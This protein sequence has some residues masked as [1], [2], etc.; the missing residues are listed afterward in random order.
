[1]YAPNGRLGAAHR[2]LLYATPDGVNVGAPASNP[3]AP[4]RP[5]NAWQGLP[6]ALVRRPSTPHHEL[7]PL[8]VACGFAQ[9]AFHTPHQ[10]AAGRRPP[11]PPLHY[12]GTPHL[13]PPNSRI[14]P[15]EPTPSFYDLVPHA[16]EYM[17]SSPNIVDTDRLT[18]WNTYD[19][20]SNHD[21]RHQT[22]QNPFPP[23]WD[24]SPGH[25]R[26]SQWAHAAAYRS[27]Y[28]ALPTTPY[29]PPPRHYRPL[30]TSSI[31]S[32]P[33]LTDHQGQLSQSPVVQQWRTDNLAARSPARV[34][35]RRVDAASRRK[36]EIYRQKG[37][38]RRH[39]IATGMTGLQ[40][41]ISTPLP[42]PG[43]AKMEATAP[44]KRRKVVPATSVGVMEGVQDERS[45]HDVYDNSVSASLQTEILGTAIVEEAT[46]TPDELPQPIVD[47]YEDYK[48]SVCH[49]ELQPTRGYD[50]AERWLEQLFET[51]LQS[52]YQRRRFCHVSKG[53]IK[54]GSRYSL[55]VL[56]NATNPFEYEPAPE[57]TITIGVYGYHWYR[58]DEIHWTTLGSDQR[59]LLEQ[60]VEMDHLT[61]KHKWSTDTDKATE[62]RFHRAYWLAANRHDL[63]GLLNRCPSDDKPHDL[64][65]EKS[66]EDPD[67]EFSIS[68]A[69]LSNAWDVTEA[70]SAAAWQ[71]VEE[72][73]EALDEAWVVHGSGWQHVVVGSSEW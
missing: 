54:D 30:R 72:E 63:K 59:Q 16:R 66:E 28:V 17:A 71:A 23:T 7:S 35:K 50:F 9:E 37:E 33:N 32:S 11:T 43:S 67:T 70:E 14:I 60:C 64:I 73:V 15:Q 42:T 49:Y 6:Q 65:E 18:L 39:T 45:N 12:D 27:P 51:A 13:P 25:V 41:L 19:T 62:K 69:D 40:A 58:H 47:K 61:L 53:F 34:A 1:M 44:K 56:H 36:Q 3:N 8:H 52:E 24:H 4:A 68:E 5:T 26:Q 38:A 20:G 46:P 57:S 55:L 22:D 31:A 29:A 21:E 48:W 10:L 2:R